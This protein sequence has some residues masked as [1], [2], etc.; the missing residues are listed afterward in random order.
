MNIFLDTSSTD[1]V[2]FLFNDEFKVLD[3]IILQGYK[4]KV[5]LIVDQYKDLLQRN[6]LTNS[7]INAYYTNLGPGFFTGVRSSLVFLR[8]MCMLENKKLFYTNTFF[9]L[10]TQN[11]NQNTF[12]ID[13]QGQKRYFYDK[14]NASENIKE[15]IEVV[16]SGD[17]QITKIDY[18]E[19]KD[20]FVSYKNIFETDDLLE[21]EPLYIKMPQIGELK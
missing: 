4:K 11:P 5:D 9:I 19:M 21:I 20:N 18:F 12:F 10:Q 15:S 13:A 3:S 14:N 2:L 8:T 6:N 7:D 17:E 1:F 16:V